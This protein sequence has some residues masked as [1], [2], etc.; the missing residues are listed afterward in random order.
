M[1]QDVIISGFGGQGILL[2]GN[3]LAYAAMNEGR[4]VTYLPAY[5][6]EMRG[7]TANCTIVIS[8]RPIGSPVVG[9]PSSTIVMN[10]PSLEKFQERIKPNGLLVLNSSLVDPGEITRK[11]IES[12]A[13]PVTAIATQEGNAK[14]ANMVVLGAYLEKTAIVAQDSIEAAF[15]DVL[16]GRYHH[17]IPANLEAMEKGREFVRR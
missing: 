15:A 13:I 4:H 10:R 17:L 16:D 3:L 12:I 14:L 8:S 2:I 6:V 9:R 11:D 5:G 7:G 1:Y